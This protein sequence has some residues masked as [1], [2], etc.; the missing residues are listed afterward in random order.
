MRLGA[1]AEQSASNLKGKSHLGIYLDTSAGTDKLFFSSCGERAAEHSPAHSRALQ[2][3]AGAGECHLENFPGAAA[4]LWVLA[5]G[6]AVCW[7]A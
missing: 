2:A 7:G 4:R 6:I 1:E 5:A 3:P